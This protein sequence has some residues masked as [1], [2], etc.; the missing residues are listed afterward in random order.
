MAWFKKMDCFLAGIWCKRNKS[1][2]LNPWLTQ[3]RLGYPNTQGDSAT[4]LIA[5]YE[6]LP[7]TG[8]SQ[9]FMLRVWK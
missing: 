4:S 2:V 5:S 3:V 9:K 6:R 8:K 7:S 1:R